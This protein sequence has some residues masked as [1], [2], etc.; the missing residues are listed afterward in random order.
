MFISGPDFFSDAPD[1]IE[2]LLLSRLIFTEIDHYYVTPITDDHLRSVKDAFSD[3]DAWDQHNS[4]RSTEL[5]FNEYM[6]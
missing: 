2:N 6:T 4:Y 3:L 5:T 1:E